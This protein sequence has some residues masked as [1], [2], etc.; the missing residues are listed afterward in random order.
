MGRPEARNRPLGV[1]LACVLVGAAATLPAVARDES[2]EED[3]PLLQFDRTELRGEVLPDKALVYVLRPASMG[4]LVKSWFFVDDE[5]LGANKGSSYFFAHVDPG[6]R[7]LWSKMENVD[8]LELE[9][10]PG[11]TYFLVQRLRMGWTKARTRLELVEVDRGEKMLAR[12]GKRATLTDAGR[13]RGVELVTDFRDDRQADL[14]R[15][16]EKQ[17]ARERNR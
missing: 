11:E 7:T 10:E 13:D 15:D 12:C 9:L 17:L 2:P 6:Q 1:L 3:G 14:A 4:M 5:V 16:A 8:A